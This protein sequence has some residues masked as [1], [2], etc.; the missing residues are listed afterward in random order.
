ML[1]CSAL[2]PW[3]SAMYD[4]NSQV[5]L[6]SQ[7]LSLFKTI[8]SDLIS[9]FF[10]FF[11]CKYLQHHTWSMGHSGQVGGSLRR[12]CYPP[13]SDSILNSFSPSSFFFLLLL[14]L[15]P[16]PPLLLSFSFLAFPPP[17]KK[18]TSAHPCL[19]GRGEFWLA[20]CLFFFPFHFFFKVAI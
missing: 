9:Q 18:S 1:Q 14:V 16:P 11:F 13:T 8:K 4:N 5:G 10:F 2:W 3:C 20:A 15:L 6:V 12:G 19:E 17:E 7:S